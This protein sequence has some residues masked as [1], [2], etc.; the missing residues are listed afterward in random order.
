ME[1]MSSHRKFI[2]GKLLYDFDIVLANVYA[3]NIVTDHRLIWEELC[4]IKTSMQFQWCVRGDLNEIK[5]ISERFGCTCLD[6]GMIYFL[7]FIS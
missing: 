4:N 1:S 3:R 6:R 5:S 7:D 2:K